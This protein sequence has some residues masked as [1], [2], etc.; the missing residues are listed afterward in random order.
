MLQ[1]PKSPSLSSVLGIAAVSAMAAIAACKPAGKDA[2]APMVDDDIE[3]IERQLAVNANSLQAEGIMIAQ[4]EPSPAP[5]GATQEAAGGD[6]ALGYEDDA[7]GEAAATVS[8]DDESEEELLD[9]EPAPME[10]ADAP[11]AESVRRSNRAD[12]RY[13]RARKKDARSRCERIC[14]LGEATCE[15]AEQICALADRH[16]DEVRYEDACERAATQCRV[17]SAACTNCDD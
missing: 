9:P 8:A 4:R 12:R 5:T 16:V 7:G 3:A 6:V 1:P 11:V 2:R 13:E 10:P 14:D 15:L 17:A